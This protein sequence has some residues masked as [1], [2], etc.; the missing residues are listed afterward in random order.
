MESERKCQKRRFGSFAE[1]A[2]A[3]PETKGYP[4]NQPAIEKCP[5]CHGWHLAN[6]HAAE[7]FTRQMPPSQ[8]LNLKLGTAAEY[9]PRC[10]ILRSQCDCWDPVNQP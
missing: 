6:G 7:T 5:Q 8:K 10:G 4:R 2:N 9:C 1:A 3:R